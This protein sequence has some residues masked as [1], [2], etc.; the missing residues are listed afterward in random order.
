MTTLVRAGSATPPQGDGP[1]PVRRPSGTTVLV[2]ALLTLLLGIA[3][4][5]A[6]VTVQDTTVTWPDPAAAAG[7]P[8]ST[9]LA[10]NPPRPLGFSATVPCTALRAGGNVLSTMPVDAGGGGLVLA[11]TGTQAALTVSGHDRRGRPG[12]RG[13][14]PPRRH[15]GRGGPA[16]DPGRRAP[17]AGVRGLRGRP[18]AP[19][20]PAHHEH[21]RDAR[22][23]GP[24]RDGAHR[25]PLRLGPRAR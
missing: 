24:G 4:P 13:R 22:R 23:R 6:P 11:S 2:W 12:A 17:A 1:D 14:L 19:D 10:L 21:R 7:G 9:Q 25:R 3:V 20:V 8:V 18:A 15:R 5:L 16:G